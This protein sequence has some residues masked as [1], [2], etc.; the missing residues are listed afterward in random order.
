[1]APRKVYDVLG[2]GAVAV[3]DFLYVEKFPLPDTKQRVIGHQR[4]CGGLTAT[5]LV[6]ATRLGA[7]CGYA[8]VLGNDELS[9]FVLDTLRREGIDV[10][11]VPR[12]PAA[13]PVHSHIVVDR[14]RGTRTI[15][16]NIDGVIGGDWAVPKKLVESSRVLFVD[17]L[18]VPGMLRAAQFARD[19]GMPIVA[20]FDSDT[21]P[22]FPKLFALV[23]HLILSREFGGAITRARTPETI[24]PRLLSRTCDVAA[25]TDGS[26]GCWHMS[27]NGEGV[28]HHPAFKVKAVDTTGCGD[29][30]HGAYAFALARGLS[31]RDRFRIASA[32]AALKATQPGGQAGIPTWKALKRFL[33][34][35]SNHQS[36]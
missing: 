19:S 18:G 23:D 17:N 1:M 13:R 21:H 20:D 36:R 3:D 14:K 12:K 5:A 22:E 16:Y 33:D 11:H 29:V 24:L 10:A 34:N 6:A 26:R 27:R 8:G 28:K 30:F 9:R 2:L 15:F 35:E 25:L 7:R 32:A 4:H 31:V